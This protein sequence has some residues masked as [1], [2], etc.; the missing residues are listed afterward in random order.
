MP[1]QPHLHALGQFAHLK[2]R[3]NNGHAVCLYATDTAACLTAFQPTCACSPFS[4]SISV[5][6]L[7]RIAVHE[8]LTS[9]IETLGK[10][11][12]ISSTTSASTRSG[13]STPTFGRPGCRLAAA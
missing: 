11:D 12:T 7:L 6:S 13:C 4:P 5:L 3:C 9:H 1:R 10:S 8:T 2:A